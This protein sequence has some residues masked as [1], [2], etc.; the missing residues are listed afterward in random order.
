MS[1][2]LDR[3][4]ADLEK[5]QSIAN[6]NARAIEAMLQQMVMDQ[7]ERNAVLEV[8]AKQ[9]KQLDRHQR[10]LKGLQTENRR[11]LDLLI[12]NQTEMDDEE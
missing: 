7:E 4:E 6:S 5:T 3:I 12:N 8:I 9:Q 1:E 11:I 2:R 10:I